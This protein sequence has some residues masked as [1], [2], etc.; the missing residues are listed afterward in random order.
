MICRMGK[1]REGVN[2]TAL[3]E[4]KILQEIKHENVI[5]LIDVFFL[6]EV[7]AYSSVCKQL[8]CITV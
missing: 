3:R 6:H 7:L 1:F 4:I 8:V 2:F 5:E